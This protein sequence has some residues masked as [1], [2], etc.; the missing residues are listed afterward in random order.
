MKTYKIMKLPGQ[1]IQMN[2]SPMS[3]LIW[4]KEM[5]EKTHLK[6]ESEPDKPQNRFLMPDFVS[7]RLNSEINSL[8][9][10]PKSFR[11]MWAF[12]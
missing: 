2:F 1:G 9:M 6:L 8:Y 4:I 11:R 10:Q 7:Q 12:V 5:R 3:F